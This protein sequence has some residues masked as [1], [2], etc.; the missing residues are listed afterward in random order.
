MTSS[1]SSGTP[2]QSPPLVFDPPSPGSWELER[3]HATKP[4]LRFISAIFPSAMMRGFRRRAEELFRDRPWR[5]D[6][7]WWDTDVKPGM[8]AEARALVSQ[9]TVVF[10][11][12]YI[13]SDTLALALY[14]LGLDLA[15]LALA[16][17]RMV[18]SALG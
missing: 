16:R 12:T 1:A 4:L 6:L 2:L 5:Q 15:S 9:P 11:S 10:W 18:T 3:T 13:L 17:R 7:I 14:A 8:L